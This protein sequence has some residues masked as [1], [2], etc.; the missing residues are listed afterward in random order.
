MFLRVSNLHH[1]SELHFQNSSYEN[2]NLRAHRAIVESIAAT[3]VPDRSLS[4]A[5]KDRSLRANGFYDFPD[6]TCSPFPRVLDLYGTAEEYE[7]Q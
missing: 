6:Q 4:G 5:M 3:V 7:D 1:F 2:R